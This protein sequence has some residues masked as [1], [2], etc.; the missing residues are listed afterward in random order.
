MQ[1]QGE[2]KGAV[3]RLENLS[4][5]WTW[6]EI[7][8]I[9]GLAANAVSL[10]LMCFCHWRER[11]SR[12]K[13]EVQGW[14][15]MQLASKGEEPSAPPAPTTN[16]AISVD[17]Q[18][19]APEQGNAQMTQGVRIEESSGGFVGH[20]LSDR[21]VGDHAKQLNVPNTP[22]SLIDPTKLRNLRAHRNY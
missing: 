20:Q 2:L 1:T 16:F 4:Y 11:S 5:Q 13:Q 21:R 6:T 19:S 10:M 22:S 17:Q 18:S 15:L 7:I 8:S 9:V 12:L 3:A 14:R